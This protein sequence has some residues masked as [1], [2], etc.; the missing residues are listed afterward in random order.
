MSKHRHP[1]LQLDL[2][3]DL[4]RNLVGDPSEPLR[5]SIDVPLLPTHPLCSL[6]YDD[7][8]ELRPFLRSRTDRLHDRFRPVSD[9][10]DEND[11]RP[12]SQP[13]VERDPSRVAP[14]D[15]QDHHAIVAFRGGVQAI[16]GFGGYRHRGHEPKGEVGRRQIIVDCLRHGDDRNAAVA[17]P[18]R[19]AKRS[20]APDGDQPVNS[21]LVNVVDDEL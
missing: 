16:D 11:V 19:D 6:G 18:L 9:L 4:L 8:V 17:E 7:D 15:L 5:V 3:R 20:V 10:R 1:D 14:H 2:P 21:E 13:R 12:P